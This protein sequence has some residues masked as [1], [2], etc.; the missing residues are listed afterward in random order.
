MASSFYHDHL[1]QL[2]RAGKIAEPE[3]NEAVR[4]VLRVKF[5]LGLFDRPYTDE[6]Q[7]AGAIL[8]P[9]S[10]ELARMA[11]ER[12]M[13]LLKNAALPT[14][15]LALPLD[16]GVK[17]IA[18]IGPLADDA[19]DM[20]GSWSALGRAEDVVTL[21][22]ALV[23]RLGPDRLRYAKGASIAGKNPEGFSEAVA[24]AQQSDVVILALGENAPEMT[25]EA[26][27]RAHL[28]LPGEQVELLKA[29]VATGKPVVLVLFSG[30]PLTLPWAFEHIPA[31]LEAWF[32]GVQAGPALV[33]T[34]FGELNPGGKLTVTWPRAVGQ[35]PFYYNAL[36][37][38]RPAGNTDLSHPPANGTE[39]Y[40]SRYIDEQNSPQF[41][42]GYGLSYT[43]FRY[44]PAQVD[45]ESLSA[46]KANDALTTSGPSPM[47]TGMVSAD[48]TNVGTRPGN[49]TVQLYVRLEGTS[50][51]EPVRALK[52]FQHIALAPGETRRVTFRLTP[53]TFAF[54]GAQNRFGVEPARVTLWIGPDSA[55]GSSATF[56]IVP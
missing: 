33:K 48:V 46:K 3:L 35:E 1:A 22:G 6:A 26:A 11:A 50:V 23:Q 32:P 56:E 47:A 27:S 8:Q 51:A 39:K 55:R 12:S 5:A 43:D 4:R 2:V 16:D 30:R 28:G 34:L 37:T 21:R 49:E 7:E 19:G 15:S 53:E 44:G 20:L 18:L 52:G 40:V 24:A 45:I 17:T 13:V 41:P 9:G 29:V 38:G 31:V 54:W 42:F 25:G 36:N 14:G 10:L